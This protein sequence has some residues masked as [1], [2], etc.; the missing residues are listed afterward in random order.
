MALSNSFLSAPLE[1]FSLAVGKA[2]YPQ[3]A[4]KHIVMPSRSSQAAIFILRTEFVKG[5]SSIML[6]AANL[7]DFV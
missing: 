5:E 6:D 3:K 7:I 4:G 1:T 2:S